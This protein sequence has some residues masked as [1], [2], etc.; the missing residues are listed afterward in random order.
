M[1]LWRVIVCRSTVLLAAFGTAALVLTM[2]PAQADGSPAERSWEIIT[3]QKVDASRLPTVFGE[4]CDSGTW[5]PV[6]DFLI[7]DARSQNRYYCQEGWSEGGQ[8]VRGKR[9]LPL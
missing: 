3:C 7:V 2:T 1:E 8:W 5:G 6:D 4:D 9:C